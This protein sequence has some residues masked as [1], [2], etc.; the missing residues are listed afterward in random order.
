[1]FCARR[2]G[3]EA[4]WQLGHSGRSIASGSMQL[5][6]LKVYHLVPCNRRLHHAPGTLPTTQGPLPLQSG[7]FMRTG[8]PLLMG[9]Q[10]GL[11]NAKAEASLAK[12]MRTLYHLR[13][14]YVLVLC[15]V[16]AC[17]IS[18]LAYFYEAMPLCPMRLR[19]TQRAVDR[20]LTRALCVPPNVRKAL[21]WM[22]VAG[23]GLQLRPPVQPDASPACSGVSQGQGFAKRARSLKRPRPPSP[24]P[25]ERLGLPGPRTR[26]PH[27][28]RDPPRGARSPGRR[29]AARGRGQPGV[30]AVRVRRGPP[31]RGWSDGGHASWRHLGC[32]AL[33]ADVAGLLANV[34][35]GV[36]LRAASHWAGEWARKLE[37]WHLADTLRIAPAAIHLRA[38]LGGEG[39][40]PS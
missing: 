3:G 9:E 4:T 12:I 40:V 21:L 28:G 32:G 14:A 29:G 34:A 25:L 26:V 7:G 20:V 31:G 39:G 38:P 18:A 33:V 30:Q 1:M 13:P 15:I 35:S 16:F 22:P 5:G 17:V 8:I 23:W 27:Q 2:G 36:L 24:E 10:P 11:Q 37:A 6:K 19:R